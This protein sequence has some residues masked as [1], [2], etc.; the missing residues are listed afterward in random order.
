MNRQAQKAVF[1]FMEK[2]MALLKIS[3]KPS[4]RRR[5]KKIWQSLPHNQRTPEKCYEVLIEE[6]K[7]RS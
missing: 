7:Y 5:V 2:E 6:I 4:M 3:L 1:S